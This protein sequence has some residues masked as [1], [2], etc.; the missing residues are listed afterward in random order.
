MMSGTWHDARREL[1]CWTAR[2][3]KAKFWVRDDDACE[4][5][6]SL[7]RLHDLATR[8]DITIGLAT[9]PGKLRPCLMQF[10]KDEGRRFHPMCHGWQH[11]NYAPAGRKPSEFGVERPISTLIEDAQ[12]ALCTFR[13]HFPG[14][15]AVF[16]P[17]FG[18]ISRALTRSLPRIGFAGI[19]AGPGWLERKLWHLPSWNVHIP[20]TSRANMRRWFGIPRL[21]VQ[22][23]P[24][25]WHG[26]T[27]HSADKMCNAIVRC[28]RLRR[29]GFLASDMPVGF[30]THHLD[31]DDK[32]WRMCSD[33][34]DLLRNHD[35]VEFLHV[36]EFFGA[37]RRND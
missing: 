26:R 35:A 34:L 16:V 9:I 29:L 27:A 14:T 37:I 17:P 28:L 12:S 1:D 8:Y 22:I 4:M 7:A 31:H 33:V 30:L 6:S 23:D 36:G 3:L 11:V 19:S 2:G 18:Q 15:D 21:D 24:I 25:D 20:G 10:M 13:R 32:I 5:S